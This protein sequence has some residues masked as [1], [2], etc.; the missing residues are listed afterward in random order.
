MWATLCVAFPCNKLMNTFPS[1]LKQLQVYWNSLSHCRWVSLTT[2]F[3]KFSRV[4][5]LLSLFWY[6]KAAFRHK[7]N[8]LDTPYSGEVLAWTQMSAV[9]E[10][11]LHPASEYKVPRNTGAVD[12]WAQQEIPHWIHRQ[13]VGELMT[14]QTHDR[15]KNEKTKQRENNYLPASVCSTRLLH[16]SFE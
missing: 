7:L 1:S 9:T 15:H 14:L 11:F 16:L 8:S 13:R 6:S 5:S 12:V 3:V 2:Q 4:V 10:D